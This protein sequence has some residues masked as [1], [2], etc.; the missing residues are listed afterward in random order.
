MP[1]IHI[2]IGKRTLTR[3]EYLR[4]QPLS[5]RTAD[6]RS[7][8]TFQHNPAPRYNGHVIRPT[9]QPDTVTATH[10]YEC[11][12][13]YTMSLRK[14]LL[15]I[16]L[17]NRHEYLSNTELRALLTKAGT[18][19]SRSGIEYELTYIK[20]AL[21]PQGVFNITTRRDK[22]HKVFVYKYTGSIAQESSIPGLVDQY[23]PEVDKSY[24]IVRAMK[25]ELKS[26]NAGTG[27]T[28]AALTPHLAALTPEAPT[29]VVQTIR[30]KV[31][32]DVH[33]SVK[34]QE[35]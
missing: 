10:I 6:I 19:V 21:E 31:H 17:K 15:T 9:P 33:F 27:K 16:L 28:P 29:E 14:D 20:H 23:L 2:R 18:N 1:D 34:L 30:L 8:A 24:K 12:R 3:A 32:V 13:P 26:L 22:N 4:T 25:A 35:D 5:E 11:R 7:C